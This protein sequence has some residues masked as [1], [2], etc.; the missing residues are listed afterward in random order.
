MERQVNILAT[1]TDDLNLIP[2]TYMVE[3]KNQLLQVNIHM[4]A[5]A[6]TCPP[7]ITS[8]PKTHTHTYGGEWKKNTERNLLK[9]D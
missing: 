1:Q 2:K 3:G 8:K 4:W 9:Y 7:K 5:M 6:H